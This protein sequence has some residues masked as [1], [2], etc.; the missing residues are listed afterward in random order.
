[1]TE[2]NF[3]PLTF[4][5]LRAAV[6]GP[7]AA[8]R[9][10]TRLEPDSGPDGKVFPPTYAGGV[11]A[12]ERRRNGSG[13]CDVVLL[14]SVQSQAN[15]LELALLQAY[16]DG[17]LKFP[18]MWVKFPAVLVPGGRITALEAPHRIADAIFRDSTLNKLPFRPQS[19]AGGAKDKSKCSPEGERFASATVRNATAMFELCPTAL[20]FGVWDSTGAAG[21]LGNK[22]ARVL[23]SEIVGVNALIGVRTSSRIDPLGITKV[24]LYEDANGDWTS[25]ESKAKRNDKGE[26]MLFARK[27]KSKD[28]GKPTEINHSNVTPDIVRY[29]DNANSRDVMKR[30][31]INFNYSVASRDGDVSGRSFLKT[32]SATVRK[33]EVAPGG[34]TITHALQ[35][36]V[37]SLPGLR[38]LRFPDDDG[39]SSTSERNIAA[40]T[41]LAALALAA[42]TYQRELQGYDL[43]SRC[44]LV[45][46]DD[47]LVFEIVTT[48]KDVAKFTQEPKQAADI[49]QQAVKAAKTAELR[50]REEPLELQPKPALVEL[51]QLSRDITDSAEEE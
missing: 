40:R 28:K 1:M 11:Y 41:V 30:E 39:K 5:Q 51:V 24:R 36:T 47:Q 22:F 12:M 16:D 3:Q 34:V 37:I 48:A 29:T 18:L 8:I 43:R 25:N 21:G 6:A 44:N 50:W 4:D 31:E 19:K 10:V 35:T 38:R 2:P 42:I 20:I 17:E 49:F 23:V 32:D 45:P 26:P 15:R 13:E 9:L 14:D 33:G 46:V 7:A 27:D